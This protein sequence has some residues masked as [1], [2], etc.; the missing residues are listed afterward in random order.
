MCIASG[1][2]VDIPF[3][4]TKDV[5]EEA[6]GRYLIEYLP[7]NNSDRVPLQIEG[8]ETVFVLGKVLAEKTLNLADNLKISIADLTRA[9]HGTLDW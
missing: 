2:G 9:W 7:H 6:P 3:W 5:F 1:F 8:A 4:P